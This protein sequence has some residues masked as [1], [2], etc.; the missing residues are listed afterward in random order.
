MND[1]KHKYFVKFDKT[2]NNW[3]PN[4]SYNLLFIQC[5]QNWLNDKLR[6]C[7]VVFLN[8]AYEALGMGRTKVGQIEGWSIDAGD[9]SYVDFSLEHGDDGAITIG[10]NVQGEVVNALP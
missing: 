8:E 3:S 6:A 2:N 10:F 1:T 9:E 4:G 5:Q 7:G